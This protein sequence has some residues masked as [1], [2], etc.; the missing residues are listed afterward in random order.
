MGNV[1]KADGLI[2]RFGDLLVIDNWSLELKEGEKIVLLGPSGC[3]KTTFFRIVAGLERQSEGKV[4]TFVDKIGYVFQEP[5]LLPWR[6]VY[7]NL[8]II[9]DDEK[10]IKQIIG[11]MGLEGFEILLPSRLSGGMKQRVNIA[12]SLLVQPQ[13]L[14]MDE[15]FTSLDLNIKLSII[16]DM[17][18]M[19]NK[20]YFSILMVTHDIKEALM[21]GNKIVILSQRPSRILKVFDIDLLEEEKNIYDKRFLELESQITKFVISQSEKIIG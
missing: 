2:K 11:M 9:L 20:S 3:G 6:T 13:I 16:E 15:P 19:W 18:K 8:K 7:D 1:L 17:N 10:K 14:L 21:L 4:E 12:R 5:R